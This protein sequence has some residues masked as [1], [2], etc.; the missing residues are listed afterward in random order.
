NR[1]KRRFP[2]LLAEPGAPPFQTMIVLGVDYHHFD[3]PAALRDDPSRGIVAS[4]AWGDD[5]HEIIRPL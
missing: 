1:E 2:T 3:L 5:Y 4:Y